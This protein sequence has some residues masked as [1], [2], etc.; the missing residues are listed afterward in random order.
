MNDDAAALR[1]ALKPLLEVIGGEFVDVADM[2]PGDVA[3]VF[4]CTPAL[5]VRVLGLEGA[6]DRMVQQIEV[7]VGGALSS[8]DRVEKQRAIR[9]LDERGAFLLRRSIDDV[10]DLM[11]VSR[12]TIY[13]YLNTIRD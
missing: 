7:E 9:L 10:A 11:D 6:L 12:I 1:D 2:E 3:I 8:L 13:N 4:D 5:A